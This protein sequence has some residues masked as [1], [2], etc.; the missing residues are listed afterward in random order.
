ME[1]CNIFLWDLRKI[2]RICF[3]VPPYSSWLYFNKM[4]Q[5]CIVG[6]LD[7]NHCNMISN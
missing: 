1:D 6:S 5:M 4:Y 2:A 7:N 3:V